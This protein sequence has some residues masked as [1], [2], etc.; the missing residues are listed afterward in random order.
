MDLFL[1]GF[2]FKYFSASYKMLQAHL[3]FSHPET[4][5]QPFS[6]RALKKP[7]TNA[8]SW[9]ASWGGGGSQ[10]LHSD[11]PRWRNLIREKLPITSI[12]AAPAHLLPSPPI[13]QM[14]KVG[15]RGEPPQGTR[16]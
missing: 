10:K 11:Q 14:G 13:S 5:N 1:S 12:W 8:D 3:V 6:Q 2:V 7:F 9:F 16:Q 4:Q 15:V